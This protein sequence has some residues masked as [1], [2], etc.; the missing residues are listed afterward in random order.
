VGGAGG[1]SAPPRALAPLAAVGAVWP[2]GARRYDAD[3][4]GAR[5]GTVHE[6]LLE[7]LLAEPYYA[8]PPPV[9]SAT[10]AS[11]RALAGPVSKATGSRPS[12]TTET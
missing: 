5:A 11:S 1:A 9:A 6:G 12:A 3:G 7:L 2:G 10:P 4:A 8:A